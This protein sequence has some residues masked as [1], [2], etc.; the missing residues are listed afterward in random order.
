[1]SHKW[2]CFSKHFG[3]NLQNDLARVAFVRRPPSYLKSLRDISN[4]AGLRSHTTALRWRTTDMSPQAQLLRNSHK[5]WNRKLALE[6]E[7]IVAGFV[8]FRD[9]LRMETGLKTIRTF[10]RNRFRI[11]VESRYVLRLCDRHH[12]SY[13]DFVHASSAEF[14]QY[15]RLKAIELLRY[16]QSE[17]IEPANLWSID[18][19]EFLPR[20]ESTRQLGPKGRYQSFSCPTFHLPFSPFSLS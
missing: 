9:C 17:K 8:V 10:I 13:R 12:L 3:P 15:K 2:R 14:S 7:Q 16:I 11:A 18:K 4:A 19:A 20:S 1:M 6:H 5:A